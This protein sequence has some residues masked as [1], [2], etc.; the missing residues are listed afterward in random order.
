MTRRSLGVRNSP[1]ASGSVAGP[2]SNRLAADGDGAADGERAADG[3]G[4]V[5]G[6]QDWLTAAEWTGSN[7]RR[8][9][10][11]AADPDLADFRRGRPPYRGR[12]RTPNPGCRRKPAGRRGPVAGRPVIKHI[13]GDGSHVSYRY[14]GTAIVIDEAG[15]LRVAGSLPGSAGTV[16]EA[17]GRVW[18]LGF[19]Q[20]TDADPAPSARELL[21]DEGRLAARLDLGLQRPV[22]VVGRFV[23]D[24]GSPHGAGDSDFA[25]RPRAPVMRFVP[26]DGGAHRPVEAPGLSRYPGP[27][28]RARDGEV[29][30]GNPG[31]SALTVAAPGR[32]RVRELALTLDIRPWMPRPQLPDDL[33]PAR[34]EQAQLDCSAGGSWA[35]RRIRWATTW[36]GRPGQPVSR[37]TRRSRVSVPRLSR[38][39][40][41]L[42]RSSTEC[43]STRSNCAERFPT[44]RS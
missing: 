42:S 19:D 26:L 25:P 21:P 4:Q 1:G 17:A 27:A 15:T 33:D 44:A 24:I 6:D 12:S 13:H 41:R 10:V 38:S 28:V 29:W 8:Q 20:E 7:G 18:L 30:L 32:A 22:A 36:P 37:I 43:P 11:E 2:A 14:P 23:V 16:C 34:F 9:A 35:D 3:D 31:A 39:S 40:R 5:D